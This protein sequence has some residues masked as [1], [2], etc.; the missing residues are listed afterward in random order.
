MSLLRYTEHDLRPLLVRS[1]SIRWPQ[2]RLMLL[3]RGRREADGTPP[4][5]ASVP[6]P[7]PVEVE[8]GEGYVAAT[9]RRLLFQ[10]RASSF[11][12]LR[13][14][15]G[16]FLLLAVVSLVMSDDVLGALAVGGV[17]LAVWGLAGLRELLTIGADISFDRVL[18]TDF[19][20]Q[21]IEGFTA[22]GVLYRVHVPDPSDFAAIASIVDGRD[23][24]HAA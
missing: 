20:S 6:S 1:I 8:G 2:E 11:S 13:A 24:F 5:V 23:E 16:L 7:P 17:A 10:E 3:T 14:A 9:D 15:A 12:L 4:D 22:A 21:H 18:R 19:G